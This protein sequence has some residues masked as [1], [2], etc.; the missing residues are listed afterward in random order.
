MSKRKTE[1][2]FLS[3]WNSSEKE[4]FYEAHTNSDSN[5]EEEI[6]FPRNRNIK[7]ITS[8]DSDSDIDKCNR[9]Y[10]ECNEDTVDEILQELGHWG[11]KKNWRYRGKYDSIWQMEWI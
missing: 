4:S 8:F 1:N 3:E 2:L 9:S 5:D 10:T 11:R 6:R 7:R